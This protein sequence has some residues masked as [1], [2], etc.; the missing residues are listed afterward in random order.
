MTA[1]TSGRSVLLL[2]PADAGLHAHAALRRRALE[3]LGWTVHHVNSARNG[4]LLGRLTGARD[5]RTRVARALDSTNPDLV[6]V[7]GEDPLGHDLLTG[8]R[9]RS[10]SRWVA[11]FPHGLEAAESLW[12][13]AQ[14][15]DRVFASGSD[16][17]GVL[18]DRLREVPEWLAPAC[19]PSVHRPLRAGGEFRAN[20][21]FAGR[22][23]ARREALL[24]Q[25]V[26]F[27]LAIWGPG[28][29]RTSLRDYCR[30]ERMVM[31][32]FLRAYGGASVAVN[33]HHTADGV[34][35]GRDTGCNRRL[36]ELAA[37]GSAQ[38]VDDR[39]DLHDCF[40]AGEEIRVFRSAQELR[41]HVEELLHD[42]PAAEAMGDSAR[43]RAMRE[44]TYMHRLRH[45]V[46]TVGFAS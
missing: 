44:H 5:L 6:L 11:W 27:G 42:L 4:G 31:D 15:Y 28:W 41:G 45:L 8:L 18:G 35:A 20:V 14:A 30:G 29:R 17:A 24:A 1:P 13:E 38:V 10:S 2:E 12:E 7:S 40:T 34:L 26:E 21:V 22:A 19:D 43:R 25:L 3:R 39:A 23:T 46:R 32:D 16:V 37:I 9:S 36:F 33:I